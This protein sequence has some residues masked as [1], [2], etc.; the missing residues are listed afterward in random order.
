M[1][2]NLDTQNK[3]NPFGTQE[4]P[5]RVQ[6]LIRQ[7]IED[8]FAHTLMSYPAVQKEFGIWLQE[9]YA[10]R[11]ASQKTQRQE[12]RTIRAAAERGSG[13]ETLEQEMD[14]HIM[15][16]RNPVPNKD[17]NYRLS[18]LITRETFEKMARYA[19]TNACTL[20]QQDGLTIFVATCM[21]GLRT[22]EWETAQLE[23]FNPE[24]QPGEVSAYPI[25]KVQTA[26]TRKVESESR[27]L[28]LEG[29]SQGNL[30]VLQNAI[31]IMTRA[32]PGMKASLIREM[33]Q[34]LRNIYS[35][36]PDHY[37]LM[38]HVDYRTARKI[39]TVE[40]LRGGATKQQ[41]AGALG[42]TTIVNLRWYAQGDT[43]MARQTTLPLARVSKEAAEKVRD[44]LHELNE[45]RQLQGQPSIHGYPDHNDSKNP[46]PSNQASDDSTAGSPDSGQSFLDKF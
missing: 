20:T 13:M 16:S 29:F 10:T 24:I 39:F 23:T 28:I 30:Q 8:R 41:A 14:R 33:R 42:H 43:H 32:T 9:Y 31:Q 46:S 18:H 3:A 4:L 25:L 40:S 15:D 6:S 36:N 21:T 1:I 27:I 38:A 35:D 12:M 26:K 34:A 17:I 22:S 44:T 2:I 11:T 7:F 37:D 45:R 19:D 5:P